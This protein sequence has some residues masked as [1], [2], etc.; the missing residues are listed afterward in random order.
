MTFPRHI[1]FGLVAT[2]AVGALGA[3]KDEDTTEAT[4]A[5]FPWD[6][7]NAGKA[8]AFGRH[9]VGIADPYEADESL[10]ER[11]DELRGNMAARREAA[12]GTVFKV[13]QPVPLVGL[14]EDIAEHEEI[15]LPEVPEV[16]RFQ[17]WYGLGDFK[18]VF[19]H[20]YEDLGPADRRVRA[21]FS[22]EAIDQAL[23]W[24][25]GALERSSSWPLQRY[26]DHANRLGECPD[27]MTKEEC[28]ALFEQKAAGAA[29]GIARITYGPSTLTHVLENYGGVL[30]CLGDLDTLS[31]DA[32]PD[33]EDNFTLC[34]D[35]EFPNDS[36]LVKA[37]WDRVGFGRKLPAWDTDAD[38][39][40]RRL[41]QSADWG[42]DGDREVDPGAKDIYTIQLR[43]G[44]VYRLAGLHI[45]TK[46]LRHWQWTTLWWSDRPESDFGADRPA[47]I[48][49]E[50]PSVWS[51]YKMCTTTFFDEE[52][53]DIREHFANL[54]SLADALGATGDEGPTWCSNPYIEHGR[55][56]AGTNCIGCHQ[57]G[58]ATVA[59]DTDFDDILDPLDLEVLIDDEDNFPEYGRIQQREVF[60]ADYLFSFNRVDDFSQMM[61]AE[62]DHFDFRD[63]EAVRPRVDAIAE[64]EGD[65]AAGAEMFAERC[66]G[67]HGP[68]GEGSG[69]APSLF[70]RVPLRDDASI[71]RTLVQGRGRMPAWGETL[72]DQEI[73]D[74]FAYLRG[75]FDE[76]DPG[77]TGPLVDEHAVLWRAETIE[78]ETGVLEPGHYTFRMTHDPTNPGGDADLYVRVGE[79]PSIVEF[80]CRPYT[81]GSDESCEVELEES[82]NI[83]VMV[84]GFQS[85]DNAFVLTGA[86]SDG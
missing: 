14:A 38:A 61:K 17:T 9:L 5:A 27:E 58:G 8:D 30:D 66:T 53:G 65:E 1:A 35:E 81:W 45:M 22:P 43:N 57:H 68:T 7:D 2:L 59:V 74:I 69:F 39:L 34:F 76:A 21:P 73:A 79:A 85:R 4:A 26:L 33:S 71:L 23:V 6:D 44:A 10:A 55:G 64:R 11:E 80:D 67:C 19:S 41:S 29:G 62:V 13:L 70:E 82:A 20:L 54:P 50:L 46:E 86:R 52:D 36:V 72:N 84:R 28:D 63:G 51:N 56:N 75:N 15:Q 3:C 32:E 60:P 49:D 31:M 40:T 18:R 77:E 37:Q 83:F 48:A 25:A 24:N 42:E 47:S 12:W 78:V 16:P